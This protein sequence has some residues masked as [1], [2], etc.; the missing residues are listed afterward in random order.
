[1]KKKKTNKKQKQKTKQTKPQEITVYFF[2]LLCF[3]FWE[4]FGVLNISFCI[5]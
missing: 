5:L 3:V 4:F 1:M 2:T